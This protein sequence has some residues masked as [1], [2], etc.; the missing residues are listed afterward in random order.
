MT[1]A[2]LIG[3]SG[4]LGSAFARRIDDVVAPTRAEVDLAQ[5]TPDSAAS[6]VES[7][8]PDTVINCAAWTAVDA[9]ETAEHEAN[10]VNGTP[11]GILADVAASRGIAFV[12]FSTDYVFDG[13]SYRPYREDDPPN[14]VNAYG[15]SKLIGEELALRHP[16]SLV[17][18]TS[19]VQSGTHPCFIR[20]MVE[21]AQERDT[22]RV[23]DDQTGRPTFA[24]DLAEA[25]IIAL[26]LGVTG[27]VHA[28]NSGVASWHELAEKTIELA[29]L[30]TEVVPVPSSEFE[31]QAERPLNSV[32]DLSRM[33]EL[34]IPELPSWQDTLQKTIPTIMSMYK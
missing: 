5:I 14:P 4:Q 17:I 12:T 9:A 24:D 29:G 33:S 28:A 10:A 2:L 16:G 26:D 8:S 7:I 11:V 34:G 25:T 15:R 13:T 27:L 1:A 30:D 31:T 20:K 32:L 19:W 6:L 18:R 23:V 21:L 22:L 3:A